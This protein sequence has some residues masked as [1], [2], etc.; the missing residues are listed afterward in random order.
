MPLPIKRIEKTLENTGFSRVPLAERMGFE[1]MCDCSQTDFE[2]SGE[3]R[4]WRNLTEDK[5][6]YSSLK[7]AV[8]QGFPHL[9][10][11]KTQ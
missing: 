11:S 5:R 6:K 2:S 3:N 1:P 8:F 7:T 10:V 4:T 9:F